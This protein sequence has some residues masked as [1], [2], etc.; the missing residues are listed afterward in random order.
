MIYVST[1]KTMTHSLLINYTRKLLICEYHKGYLFVLLEDHKHF[2]QM[3]T[4]WFFS[5]FLLLGMTFKRWILNKYS[6]TAVFVTF[7]SLSWWYASRENTRCKIS[8][9]GCDL[10][11]CLDITLRKR[12]WLESRERRIINVPL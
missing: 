6:F 5:R 8:F 9:P 11:L 1:L 10:W 2:Y 12:H 7:S 3:I 4:M